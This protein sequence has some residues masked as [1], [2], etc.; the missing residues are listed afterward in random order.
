MFDQLLLGFSV[1]LQPANLLY[2]LIGAVVGTAVGVLPGL[3][4]VATMALLLPM[5][6]H[7]PPVSAVIMIAGIFYG[8][9]YGGSTT[10]ILLRVP[11]E[12]SSIT[13]TLDGYQLAMQGRAGAAL[14]MSA[15]ASF[16]GGTL[17]VIGLCFAAPILS[18][19][20]LKFGPPEY[21]ALALLGLMMVVYLSEGSVV[22]GAIMGA[23]GLAAATIGLDPVNGGERFTFNIV[24]LR[25]GLELVPVAMGLF[26]I[27]EIMLNL[28][29]PENRDVLKQ[30]IS[31][32][33]PTREDWRRA[34]AP[35]T[36]G[37]LF[38]FLVGILPGG[39]AT[40]SSFIEYGI[41]KRLS[42]TPEQF[43]KGA[44]EGVAGP[45]AANNAAST[46]SFIPLLT[47]GIPGN[48]ST[49]MVLVALMIHG[50]RPGPMLMAE[51]PELFWGTV[52]SMY[53]GNIVLLCLNLPMIGLWVRLLHTPYH[54]LVLVIVVVCVVGAYSVS[55]STF[56]IGVMLV[57]GIVGYILRKAD[58]PI[59]PFLLAMILGD[60][61][62]STLQQTLV[63][64][65]GD[66]SIFLNRPIA[67]GI[68]AFGAIFMLKP[69]IARVWFAS[70]A[71]APKSTPERT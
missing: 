6:Y 31:K 46:S 13:T 4:T 40:I 25:D 60:M 70:K 32:L 7:V 18:E 38:G 21:F 26:G 43:G 61:L 58:Y 20:A 64:E 9:Q 1:A 52:A 37:S 71:S 55:N 11:G 57:F 3:G 67:A 16:I 34:W 62:E 63:A 59:A 24:Q 36:R 33:L 42:K 14:G 5:T 51:H 17:G 23:L 56:S 49:A 22:K 45:E 28:E 19:F 50:I 10:A 39:G 30:T 54:Y 53:V 48:L 65:G 15:I 12:E 44:I 2:G 41:E 68:L 47:L 8:A 69:V 66:L 35:I 27:S 29:K